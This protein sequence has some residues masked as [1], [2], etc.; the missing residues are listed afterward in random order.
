MLHWRGNERGRWGITPPLYM[1]KNAL[2]HPNSV[3]GV[4]HPNSF[5]Q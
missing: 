3:G 1:L 4:T 2:T 5:K